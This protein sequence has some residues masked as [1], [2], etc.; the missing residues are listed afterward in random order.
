GPDLRV[1][2]EEVAVVRKPDPSRRR[3]QVVVVQREVDGHHDRIAEEDGEADEPRRE[4]EE[5]ETAPPPLGA[6][7]GPPALRRGN[8][9]GDGGYGTPPPPLPPPACFT[10]ASSCESSFFRSAPR[11]FEPFAWKFCQNVCTRFVYDWPDA[12]IGDVLERGL[13]KILMN[14]SKCAFGTI[15]FDFAD[16]DVDGTFLSPFVSSA[17]ACVFVV[18]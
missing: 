6:L 16:A 4:E 11:L 15:S 5:H 17:S 1:D 18:R 12:M 3:Q 8:G 7:P 13:L 10:C 2:R 9:W 14:V